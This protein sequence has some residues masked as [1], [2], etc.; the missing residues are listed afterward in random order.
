MT[1]S[2][3][4]ETINRGHW[5]AVLDMR[6]RDVQEA[7]PDVCERLRQVALGQPVL[8]GHYPDRTLADLALIEHIPLEELLKALSD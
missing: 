4:K 1:K 8:C 7:Q 6:V 5:P 3:L 2:V